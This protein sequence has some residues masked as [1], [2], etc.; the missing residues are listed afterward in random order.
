MHVSSFAKSTFWHFALRRKQ[1]RTWPVIVLDRYGDFSM[2]DST[3][4]PW[5][6]V[7][8]EKKNRYREIYVLHN[9]QRVI[10]LEF[11]T[12]FFRFDKFGITDVYQNLLSV[13]DYHKYRRKKG[14]LLFKACIFLIRT[15]LICCKIWVEISITNT[16]VVLRS[17]FGIRARRCKV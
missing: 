9:V 5:A 17:T 16:Q 6:S 14:I 7:I 4:R 11:S 15:C 12:Y 3:L 10:V 2:Q 1:I 8:V 13:W